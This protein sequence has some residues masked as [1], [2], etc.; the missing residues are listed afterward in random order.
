MTN[1]LL[2]MMLEFFK[3]AFI[4]FTDSKTEKCSDGLVFLFGW[5]MGRILLN[6]LL[7]YNNGDCDG[8]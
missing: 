8:R 1:K 3:G 2:A 7:G 6:V 5:G 4:F